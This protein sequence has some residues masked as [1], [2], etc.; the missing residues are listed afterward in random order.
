ML[1]KK[2]L[3]MFV[4]SFLFLNVFAQEVN[5]G[6][7]KQ[8]VGR[9]SDTWWYDNGDGTFPASTWMWID[10]NADGRAECYYFDEAGRMLSDT[11]T[12]DGYT[13]DENGAWTLG[14]VRQKYVLNPYQMEIFKDAAEGLL[15]LY[16][17]A[18][19]VPSKVFVQLPHRMTDEES[20]ELLNRMLAADTEKRL[21]NSETTTLFT[22]LRLESGAGY[23]DRK[24]T[25]DAF[26]TVFGVGLNADYI[27][28]SEQGELIGKPDVKSV[29][30]R[31]VSCETD[32]DGS[33]LYMK[34]KYEKMDVQTSKI[35]R[36][37]AFHMELRRNSTANIGYT[38]DVIS[39][40]ESYG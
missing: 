13:V 21:Q 38:I 17:D 40:V 28:Q 20:Q 25:L 7:W 8:G 34:F 37:G 36:T 4:V 33:F 5:A 29:R 15:S 3:A 35:L 27:P 12:P 39:N 11:V 18:F 1:V 9:D 26:G 32:S 24:T 22:P 10:G 6:T 16:G 30:Y 31:I 2:V 19:Y 14:F 23:F